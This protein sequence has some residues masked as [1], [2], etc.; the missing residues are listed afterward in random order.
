MIIYDIA[1]KF[2]IRMC[3]YPAFQC[4]K[5]QGNWIMH[6]CF[7]TTFTP[8]PKRWKKNKETKPIFEGSY[9]GNAQ[10]DLFEI[11]NVR[12]WHCSAFRLQKLFGSS[13]V[14]RSYVYMKIALL[15]FLL[16]TYGCAWHAGFLGCTTHYR[17]SWLYQ[18]KL[19]MTN[20][21]YCDIASYWTVYV[22]NK[23]HCIA[24]H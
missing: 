12:W 15:F 3:L 20:S 5:F 19:A 13:K 16:I 10:C 17:V 9:L 4:T 22:I 6:L 1:I 2:G 14:L 8:W 18:S 24:E 7:I 21:L 11:L 23:M